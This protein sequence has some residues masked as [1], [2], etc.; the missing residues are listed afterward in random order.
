MSPKDTPPAPRA[1]IRTV[2]ADAGVSVAA[3][4]KVLRNAY[5]VSDALRARVTAS[6]E[7]LG[8]RPS[9]A[10]Q[11]LRGR[12]TTV[13]VLLVEIG[14]PFLPFVI[15]GVQDVLAPSHY[16][17]MIGVGRAQTH[18]ETELVESMIDHGMAGL[19][20][21]APLLPAEV[22]SRYAR[23]VPTVLVAYHEPGDTPY[24]TVN[25]DDRRGAALATEG[26]LARGH[27]DVGFLAQRSSQG[28]RANV[29]TEREKGYG[30]AMAAAGLPPR[31]F[32]LV[33]P[34]DGR[35]AELAAFLRRPDRPRAAVV[36]S[37]L[38]AIPLRGLAARA[39]VRVPEDLALVGYDNSPMAGFPL[40]DLASIDQQG[41]EIGRQAAE[42]LLGR[43]GG[44]SEPRHLLIEP[45]LVAR[46]SL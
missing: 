4:S 11:G 30:D 32:D 23:R 15:D 38:D 33:A 25:S 5:G 41:R 26:L 12:S 36:W 44:R 27:R 39:G 45:H 2:A 20:L 7:K 16:R 19:I 17:A 29:A 21:V 28:R 9:K 37:D 13:G 42:A 35:E 1:T 31:V 43:I 18:L 8:Y 14:N 34:P 40:V 22:V 24:D 3:V 10:A 6:I 46:S